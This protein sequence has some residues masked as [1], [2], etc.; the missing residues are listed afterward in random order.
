MAAMMC[1]E[2]TFCPGLNCT[3]HTSVLP[4]Q[5][6]LPL[7]RGLPPTNN[8][9]HVNSGSSP[10]VPDT[11]LHVHDSPSQSEIYPVSHVDLMA[12]C[13]FQ[14]FL[15]LLIFW[16][17]TEKCTAIFG[18]PHPLQRSYPS[19]VEEEMD[20]KRI[21]SLSG[22]LPSCL[23]YCI[24]YQQ[25]RFLFGFCC[26]VWLVFFKSHFWFYSCKN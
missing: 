2:S 15:D 7:L 17:G 4:K 14:H 1:Q 10:Y 9:L 24:A 12:S 13:Y 23:P 22:N 25:T 20:R 5:F 21:I 6:C 11:R 8:F 19:P 18:P 26:C 3:L 16:Q